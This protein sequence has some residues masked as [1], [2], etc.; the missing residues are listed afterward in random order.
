M[1]KV[2][3]IQ[4]ET[5]I[6]AVDLKARQKSDLLEK[7]GELLTR[8]KDHK[9]S[10]KEETFTL[11]DMADFIHTEI[12]D[13]KENELLFLLV[14]KFKIAINRQHFRPDEAEID[15]RKKF[16]VTELDNVFTDLCDKNQK[17]IQIVSGFLGE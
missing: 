17:E 16:D 12:I 3:N 5:L 7:L 10:F 6:R 15:P 14:A 8:Y 13:R 11:Y 4:M 2:S 9:V 1:P